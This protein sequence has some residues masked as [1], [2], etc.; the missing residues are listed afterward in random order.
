MES[1]EVIFWD[2]DQLLHAELLIRDKMF[3]YLV[4]CGGSRV[5]TR[6]PKNTACNIFGFVLW[7]CTYVHGRVLLSHCSFSCLYLVFSE[8]VRRSRY[9]W[10]KRNENGKLH[11]VPFCIPGFRIIVVYVCV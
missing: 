4:F 1:N 6:L 9:N 3:N 10:C 11:Q 2:D 7:F 5:I 8:S